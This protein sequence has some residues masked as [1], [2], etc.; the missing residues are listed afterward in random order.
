MNKQS[1]KK[2][3]VTAETVRVLSQPELTKAAG[4]ITT[5]MTCTCTK[6]SIRI[7]CTTAAACT[8]TIY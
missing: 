5:Y 4:G 1:K 6:P 3:S 2:L 8:T 7:A